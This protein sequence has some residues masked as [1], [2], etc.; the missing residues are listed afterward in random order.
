ME[1]T[2]DDDAVYGKKETPLTSRIK[3]TLDNL[4]DGRLITT[5][6]LADIM[7]CNP[8]TIKNSQHRFCDYSIVTLVKTNNTRVQ[9]RLFGNVRTIEAWKKK[10]LR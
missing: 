1:F 3:K 9:K 5:V 4:E 2:I 10:N 6:R 7:D 8:S